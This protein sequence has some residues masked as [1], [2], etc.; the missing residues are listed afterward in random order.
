MQTSQA[1]TDPKLK[2][3]AQIEKLLPKDKKV[4]IAPLV[5]RPLGKPTLVPVGTGRKE[6]EGVFTELPDGG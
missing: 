2:S 5:H 3:P 1:Y 6:I 4:A